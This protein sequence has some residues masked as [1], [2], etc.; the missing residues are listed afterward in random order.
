M[1]TLAAVGG[2]AIMAMAVAAPASAQDG[3]SGTTTVTPDSMMTTVRGEATTRA[4]S[5]Q[6]NRGRNR[7]RT[8]NQPPAP[9]TPEE[10]I[11]AAQ[12]I[13][14]AASVPCQVSL[15]NFLGLTPDGAK[16]YEAVCATGPGY[17]LM[18]TTP[19]TTADCVLL[20]GQ[21]EIDRARDPAADLGTQCVIPQN[22]DVVRV[23]SAYASEA[24]IACPVDQGASIGKS[25]EGNLIYEVGCNG[26]DGYWIEKV[27]AGWKT[28]ECAIVTTQSATCRYS[29]VAE[30]VATF[31]NRIAGSEAAPCDVTEGRYMGANANGAFWEARCGA[32]N[33]V[34]VRF[35]PQYAVQQV[36][37]CETAQRIGG[38]CRLTIVP[39]A[40]AVPA[41]AAEQ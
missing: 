25:S 3:Q 24:G 8:R 9:P 22:V 41:P 30:Q 36:Y 4:P 38:G 34:I 19:P 20:A 6:D 7:E 31:K 40:P 10:N 33:G 1:K 28:T 18:A 27:A 13:A 29:T 17:I 26:V 39:E 15:A 14:A 21:A 2:A 12:A 5:G 32:G 37:P 11:A 35:N 16:S 23:I